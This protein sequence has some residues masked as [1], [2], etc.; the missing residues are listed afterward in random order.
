MLVF[1]QIEMVKK[2]YLVPVVLPWISQLSQI[3]KSN[4]ELLSKGTLSLLL[5]SMTTMIQDHNGGSANIN[6]QILAIADNL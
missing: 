1:K 3:L 6:H 5:E 2:K 4:H